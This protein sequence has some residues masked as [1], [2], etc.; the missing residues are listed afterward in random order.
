MTSPRRV[1]SY[2]FLKSLS[3]ITQLTLSCLAFMI[4]CAIRRPDGS[5][6]PFQV[7]SDISLD[8]LHYTVGKKLGRFPAQVLL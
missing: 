1:V 4:Q 3:D 2:D 6:S 7:S 8:N 5:N